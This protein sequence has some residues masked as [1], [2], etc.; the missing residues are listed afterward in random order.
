MATRPS[1]DFVFATSGTKVDPGAP[2]KDVGF[3][4]AERIPAS[5]LNYL[6]NLVAQWL[7]YL[8]AVTLEISNKLPGTFVFRK[9]LM[10]VPGATVSAGS[11][12]T[13]LVPGEL[14]GSADTNTS[15]T[16]RP[17]DNVT[18]RS[19]FPHADL[20]VLNAAVNQGCSVFSNSSTASAQLIGQLDNV[21][22]VYEVAVC[23][24]AVGANGVDVGVGLLEVPN[25]NNPSTADA[26]VI[27]IKESG[28][29]NW[30][31]QV[32]NGS[33]ITEVDTGVPPVADSWQLLRAEFHGASTPV[34]VSN[35]SATARFFIDGVQVA[36]ITG[37]NVPSGLI[38]GLGI[39]GHARA[40]GT[41]PAADF[42]F[43]ISPISIAWKP[44]LS[45]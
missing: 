43:R 21:V 38:K 17:P 24:L 14:S 19:P 26:S 15:I 8:E 10:W 42:R 9:C 4:T 12:N 25:L 13:S 39:N 35:A 41:G 20:T 11:S 29:T 30:Q 32:C 31:A 23:M 16:V 3:V 2:K 33:A 7:G 40:N 45:P 34:G 22:A 6:F 28:D 36:E 18:F 27:F 37:A 5:W 44:F 1:Q